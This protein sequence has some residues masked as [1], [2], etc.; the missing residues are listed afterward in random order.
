MAIAHG[1]L[2]VADGA[3]ITVRFALPRAVLARRLRAGAAIPGPLSVPALL[4]TCAQVTCVD[5]S[6]IARLGASPALVTMAN[7]AA[8]SGLA[9]TLRYELA[10]TVGDPA[11]ATSLLEVPDLEV[12]E[13]PLAGLGYEALIGRDVLAQCVLVYD[14]LTNSFALAY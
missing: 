2:T 1:I 10:L 4:D 6:V 9:P 5:P 8:M 11:T 12:L 14:G 13:V 3:V 7:L